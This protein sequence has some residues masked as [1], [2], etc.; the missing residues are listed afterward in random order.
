MI[1]GP[2]LRAARDTAGRTTRTRAL[3]SRRRRNRSGNC[4]RN[5]VAPIVRNAELDG[6]IVEQIGLAL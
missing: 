4:C 6:Q 3:P 2:R 5:R 1:F